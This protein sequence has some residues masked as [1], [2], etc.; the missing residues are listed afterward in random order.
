MLAF[1]GTKNK[2]KAQKISLKEREKKLQQING[3][4]ATKLLI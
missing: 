1:N 2:I 4:S 3:S